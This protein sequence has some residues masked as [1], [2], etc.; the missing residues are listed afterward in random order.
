MQ[1]PDGSFAYWP[2]GTETVPWAT[3]YAGMGLMMAADKGANVPESAIE[4]LTKYLIESLRGIANEEIPLR[5][6][7]PRPLADG[8]RHLRLPAARL[9]ERARRSH[10]R[11]HTQRPLPARHRHRRRGRG[12][13]GESRHRQI[14]P[15]LQS[16]LQARR[17]TTGCPGPP[18][19]PTTSSPGSSS[20]PKA[21]NPPRP[22]TA[23]STS[24]IPTA[25]GTPPGS[26]AGA[27]WPWRN[28][29]EIRNSATPRFP[30]P[31]KPT[32]GT[33]TITLTED[34]PTAIRS[35]K[36]S[37]DLKLALS[38]DH[39]ACVRMNVA[40][41]P[42]IA[43]IQP[44]AKNGLSIDRIYERINAD[45]SADHPHRA[46]GRRPHP[47]LPPRH[48]AQ[49]RHPLP[50]HRRPA[51]LAVSK[52]STPT[53][54]PS[55]PPSASAPARTIGT[56][57]TP[58]SAAT[59]PRSSSTTSGAKAPTPLTYLARCTARRPGHRPARQGRVDV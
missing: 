9:S 20:I 16:S 48:P 32:T 15:N 10:R 25:T 23:C 19:M 59:A 14:R 49:G 50:R 11:T 51:A 7:K 47:R 1:L 34:Q 45:G 52:P 56:S 8:A 29:R 36:L 12:Q 33:E 55:A 40:A 58:N 43:P 6:R 41:K 24:A 5:P 44:V 35:F 42:Q 3:S 13:R 17:T 57:A 46:K 37:P 28:T 31:S 2:G 30:S 18:T 54:N 38:A 39:S 21:R 27:S 26:T 22:S 4:S 53:S